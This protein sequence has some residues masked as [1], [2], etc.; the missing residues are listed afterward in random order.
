[1]KQKIFKED[2]QKLN[3]YIQKI[4]DVIGPLSYRDELLSIMDEEE[5]NRLYEQYPKCF[6]PVNIG[7]KDIP[8][9]PICNRMGATDKNMIAFSLK[10]ANRLIGRED[11]N[12]GMLEITIQKLERLN[13]KYSKDEVHPSDIAALK[14]NSTKSLNKIKEYIKGLKD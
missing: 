11:V 4:N 5:R 13:N 3:E 7:N 2:F 6:L 1:M 9:L 14:G 12:R 8:F 10:L